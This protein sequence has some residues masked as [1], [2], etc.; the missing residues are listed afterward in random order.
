MTSDAKVGLLLGL[1]FIFVI[2]FIINGLPGFN[3]ST[4]P[5]Q[6]GNNQLTQ[7]MVKA[8]ERPIVLGAAE[9]KFDQQAKAKRIY[10]NR[11]Q[12][13][14]KSNRAA[15]NHI[16]AND[17]AKPN[18]RTRTTRTIRPI[19]DAVGVLTQA[20]K[21]PD[22]SVRFVTNL[23]TKIKTTNQNGQSPA[24]SLNQTGSIAKRMNRYQNKSKIYV[25]KSGDS[26]ASI[27]VKFYGQK[28][29][30]KLAT[31]KK[32]VAANKKSIKSADKIFVGQKLIMPSLSGDLQS[33][34]K[35]VFAVVSRQ[36]K[37]IKSLKYR[38]Y[39]VKDG[40]SLWQI[41]QQKLGNG[42]RYVEIS[43]LNRKIIADGNELTIG[44]KIRLPLK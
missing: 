42:S 8:S 44:D 43:K 28:K 4:E 32:I 22:G 5:A 31:I 6:T 3:G 34:P 20:T 17:N 15:V 24:I 27:A 36:K 39:V 38:N 11:Y 13:S 26:V 25:V 40:D 9:R 35:N 29:G 37:A 10:S 30:N 19:N 23:P 18:V 33:K 21:N 7:R 14:G 12:P 1:V 2:A 16:A 41:A